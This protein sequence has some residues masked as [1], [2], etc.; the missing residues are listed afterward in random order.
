MARRGAVIQQTEADW[1]ASVIDLAHLYGWRVAHFRK[2]RVQRSNGSIYHETP[3]AAD[4]VGFPDLVLVRPPRLIFAECKTDTGR[5]RPEQETW[6]DLLRGVAEHVRD[7]DVMAADAACVT[8]D[9]RVAVE[10]FVWRPRD[11]DEVARVLARS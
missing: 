8:P 6:L 5:L 4:G 7:L 2:V 1:Q 3:A 10:V 9:P 11:A